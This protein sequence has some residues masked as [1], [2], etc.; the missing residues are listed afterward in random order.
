MRRPV[1]S[2]GHGRNCSGPTVG[3]LHSCGPPSARW[4]PAPPTVRDARVHAQGP[5]ARPAPSF[6]VSTDLVVPSGPSS[7]GVGP[8]TNPVRF[9]SSDHR[10]LENGSQRRAWMSR[11]TTKVMWEAVKSALRI[12]PECA[13][14]LSR[15]HRAGSQKRSPRATTGPR[16]AWPPRGPCADPPPCV[17]GHSRAYRA[18]CATP[19]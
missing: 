8:P 2:G 5:S 6:Q 13:V 11:S 16:S 4:L 17:A 19:P 7:Q 10:L 12:E 14:R 3:A 15:S 9:R 18:E 1:A